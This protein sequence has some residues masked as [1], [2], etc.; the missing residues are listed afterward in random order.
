M[1]C[2]LQMKPDSVCG[3]VSLL[4]F[5]RRRKRRCFSGESNWCDTPVISCLG[6]DYGN[7]TCVY[8][9]HYNGL[10]LRGL[11]WNL[12]PLNLIFIMQLI[13]K[14]MFFFKGQQSQMLLFHLLNGAFQRGVWELVKNLWESSKF[15]LRGSG[16]VNPI[17]VFER[18]L[19]TVLSLHKIFN[20]PSFAEHQ[21]NAC[22]WLNK[23]VFFSHLF[24]FYLFLLH[25]FQEAH[26]GAHSS[27]PPSGIRTVM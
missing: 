21:K 23:W 1:C 18:A 20:L 27:Y 3:T 6:T 22:F 16:G 7:M 17:M 10:S 5:P 15:Y 25:F 12:Y 13:S 9:C 14:K 8:C 11:A 2:R 24:I 19:L 4:G 26:S